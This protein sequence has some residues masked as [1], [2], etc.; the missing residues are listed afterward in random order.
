M[1]RKAFAAFKLLNNFVSKGATNCEYMKLI[2][3][4]ELA[5]IQSQYVVEDVLLK[6]ERAIV[7]TAKMEILH[8]EALANE[9]ACDYLVCRSDKNSGKKARRFLERSLSC[10]EAWGGH[11]KVRELNSR[12]GDLLR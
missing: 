4:A 2:L 12:H 9:L 8:H 7:A 3:E 1:K 10:Y 11:A 6:F 5:T